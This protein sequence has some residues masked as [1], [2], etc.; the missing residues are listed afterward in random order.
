MAS[1]RLLLTNL[2]LIVI[3]TGVA[4]SQTSVQDYLLGRSPHERLMR[5]FA[6]F[7]KKMKRDPD[8]RRALEGMIGSDSENLQELSRND[9]AEFE[10]ALLRLE[11]GFVSKWMGCL[12][13]SMVAQ[14]RKTPM[15]TVTHGEV[16]AA[17]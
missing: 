16:A 4:L 7:E 9:R 13:N 11:A 14:A 2:A 3:G 17:F 15:R 5:H 8:I 6:E 10:A 12:H 1:H